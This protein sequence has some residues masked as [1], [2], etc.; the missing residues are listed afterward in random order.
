MPPSLT[1]RTLATYLN[2]ANIRSFLERSLGSLRGT[3]LDIGCGQA[4]YRELVLSGSDV[5]AYVGLDLDAGHYPYPGRADVRWDG[6]RMPF[7]DGSVDSALLFEVLEHCA[8]PRVVVS[9]AFRV[10]KGGSALLFS[11]P[12]LYPLHGVP[13]DYHRPTPFGLRALLSSAGFVSVEMQAGG[14]WDASLGQMLALWI[15]HRPMSSRSRALLAR[16][17]VPLFRLLLRLDRRRS[18]MP[19]EREDAMFPGLFGSA[20]KLARETDAGSGTLIAQV[21]RP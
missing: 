21:G 5:R 16:A 19:I 1:A 15:A 9:E 4:R 17:F 18:P 11:T 10:L 8:D 6:R 13:F 12:F 20:L 2:D 14:A 3:V 7:D